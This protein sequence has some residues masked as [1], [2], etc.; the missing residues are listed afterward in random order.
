MYC[1]I[2]K[3]Y[4]YNNKVICEVLSDLLS[5][6]HIIYLLIHER[7]LSIRDA[8]FASFIG[9]VQASFTEIL[10]SSC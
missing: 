2:K 8:I 4:E 7:K 5:K 1:S 3:H 10:W 9:V 6:I